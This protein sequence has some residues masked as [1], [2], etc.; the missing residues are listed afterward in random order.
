MQN[1]GIRPSSY[2]LDKQ[3]FQNADVVYWN[4]GTAQLIE[5]ALTHREGLLASGG[6]L[7]VRT[8][9]HT[10]RA[11]HD[12]FVVRDASTESTIDWGPINQPFSPRRFDRL[13]NKLLRY[14]QTRDLYVQD[15]FSGADQRHQIPIRVITE[16]AWH[17][18][19]ARQLFVRPDPLLTDRHVPEYTLIDAPGFRADP[20]EDG[21]NS[22]AFVIINFTR[23]LVI[24][25]GTAYAGEMKK[26]IFSVLNYIM[27][28]AR[29]LPMHCSANVGPQGDAA[30]LF[31]LSGT[32]KTT[33]SADPERRLIGDDEHGWTPSYVFNFEGGCY[34]KCIR[35]SK[36]HEPQIWQAIR[37]G[38]VLENVAIDTELRLLDFDDGRLTENTRAAY[39]L[40]FV[41]N[42]VIPSVGGLPKN[43]VFLTCDAF[44][45]LPPLARLTPAQA[46]Y[47][48]LSGYTAKVGGTEVGLGKEPQATFS[49]CFGAP[50][51]PRSPDVYA[52]MLGEKLKTHHAQCWLV[53]TGWTG[54]PYG[55]G[56]RMSLP[57]T[58]A[59]LH[60]ALSG[61]LDHAEYRTDPV[62]RLT[63]PNA[64]PGVESK[65]LDPRV[66]WANPSMYDR[67][68]RDLAARFRKNFEK[69]S[70]SEEIKAAE[71]ASS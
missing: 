69:F 4:L 31:G 49:A 60:A 44:G 17:N 54:G 34:A 2:G 53:N 39:P 23:K 12:K 51:L 8:G 57:I 58:R 68:V 56:Q 33:L 28:T 67:T 61:A 47:H 3:W 18:L 64:C 38:T 66:T 48:F 27:P 11:A 24:V 20:E 43:V 9:D 36:E 41:E 25:G 65:L 30:L 29:V 71:P 5:K 63:V 10:G 19:F 70:P 52:E 21:T 7:V 13:F 15:C 35:L 46:M 42:A 6:A 50:F 62:F 1:A 59:L 37:F 26:A 22:S 40:G 45:V 32:G 16:L 14:L 55:V